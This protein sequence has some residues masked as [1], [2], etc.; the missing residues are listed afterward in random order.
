MCFAKVFV[1]LI[2]FSVNKHESQ[3]ELHKYIKIQIQNKR[4]DSKKL[5]IR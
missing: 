1:Y 4:V 2:C 5:L 3:N